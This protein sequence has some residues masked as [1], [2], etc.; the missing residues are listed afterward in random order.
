MRIAI[1]IVFSLAVWAVFSCARFD[2]DGSVLGYFIAQQNP[3]V[4][5]GPSNPSD[6]S[7]RRQLTFNHGSGADNLINFPVLL[8]L[9]SGNINYA[10]TRSG[11]A[12]LLFI[13]AD[14]TELD[15]EIESWNPTG[16][17][18]VW[19]RI[20][21]I[22]ALSTTDNI[23]MYYGNPSAIDR[24]NAPAVW[25]DGYVGVWH[26]DEDPS[27]T[28]PQIGDSSGNGRNG[29]SGTGM[30]STDQVP[31]QIGGSLNFFDT[32]GFGTEEDVID[33]LNDCP[34]VTR[35]TLEFWLYPNTPDTFD[36]VFLQGSAACSL[37][38]LTV[39]WDATPGRLEFRTDT[40]GGTQASD[41]T[42][43]TIPDSTWS[44]F[45]WVFDGSAHTI[46][47]DGLPITPGSSGN[48]LNLDESLH[49]GGRDTDK[50]W[51]GGLDEI[52]LSTTVR[53]DDW[54]NSQYQAMTDTFVSFGA[55]EPAP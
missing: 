11:G 38:Q 42:S 24:Q 35:W 50:Y 43:T 3:I 9:N 14:L 30:L 47:V 39:S 10:A 32:A 31:G 12:D 18:Y 26:L 8:K 51:H 22:D 34:V 55:E 20:P 23:W 41:G 36:R 7:Y 44:H 15:Y 16:N 1:S 21:L 2:P 17:S 49:I 5:I 25:S 33:L 53:S 19:V 40:S 28:A 52:R 4:P 37:R 46:Y 13:D 54:I 6:W 45:V 48:S 29:T 27:G